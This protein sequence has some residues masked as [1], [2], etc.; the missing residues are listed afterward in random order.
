[1]DRST[2]NI[3]KYKMAKKPT[4]R[5]VSE[6]W[7][8]A[9]EDLYQRL[10]MKEGETYIYKM[11]KIQEREA[12]DVDQVKCIKDRA[13]QLLVK[14]G[15]IKHRWWGYFDKLFNVETKSSTI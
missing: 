14:D 5:A 15:Q 12:M 2:N 9:F 6:A 4:K 10:D 7:G 3:E 8:Q 11:T 13:G 1:L